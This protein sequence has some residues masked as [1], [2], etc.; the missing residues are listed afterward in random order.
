[1]PDARGDVS[2]FRSL[3]IEAEGLGF[4]NSGGELAYASRLG[5]V[6]VQI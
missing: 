2:Q 3:R 6:G 4:E 1:M 5:I